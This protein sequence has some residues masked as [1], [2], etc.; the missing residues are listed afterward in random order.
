MVTYYMEGRL[1]KGEKRRVPKMKK[2]YINISLQVVLH[3]LIS[4]LLA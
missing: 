4:T 2:L 1:S 3:L